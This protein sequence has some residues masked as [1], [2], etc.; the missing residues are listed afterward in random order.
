MN[1]PFF[2]LFVCS[3]CFIAGHL[4][5]IPFCIH[6]IAYNLIPVMFMFPLGMSIG[7]SVRMGHVLAKDVHRAKVLA[8]LCMGFT[9][10]VACIAAIVLYHLRQP[11]VALFTSDE[12]VVNGCK[13]I[14]FK[15]CVYIVL[16]YVFGINSGIMRALGMQWRMAAVVTSVLWGMALPTLMHVVVSKG[17]GVDAIWSILPCYYFL[18]NVCLIICYSTADWH[19]ISKGIQERAEQSGLEMEAASERTPLHSVKEFK[20]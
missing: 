1:I 17:G 12:Q 9:V 18:M 11:I 7:L 5:V 6:T 13:E 8:T 4:G 3:V 15:V 10:I 2:F 19:A 16:L 14:W 20:V